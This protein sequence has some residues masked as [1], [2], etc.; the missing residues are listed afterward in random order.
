[1]LHTGSIMCSKTRAAT[2][3]HWL[4]R[5]PQRLEHSYVLVTGGSRGLGLAL[6]RQFARRGA[7]VALLARSEAGLRAA[8]AQLRA[9]LGVEVEIMAC[10]L[11][12][13]A[14]IERAAADLLARWPRIDVLINN[15]G[16]VRPGPAEDKELSEY[17]EAMAVH[18]WAPL[19]LMR[20]VIPRM[21]QQGG[22]R[23]VNVSSVEGKVAF[24]HIAPYCASKFALTGLSNAL[25]AELARDRIFVTTVAPG[26]M[27]P[28]P[29]L[30][31]PAGIAREHQWIARTSAAALSIGYERAA[32]SIV[33]ACRHGQRWLELDLLTRLLIRADAFAPALVGAGMELANALLSARSE[34]SEK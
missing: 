14:Q 22:G 31:Q 20:A 10:D 8:R 1:M 7:R 18:F 24:P 4:R 2:R 19:Q 5:Q 13:R 6:A 32:R 34:L 29:G 16:I 21:R 26:L 30:P 17:E 23:I 11:R 28:G 33:R 15:A 12:Q 25:R 3:W 9:E 27:G